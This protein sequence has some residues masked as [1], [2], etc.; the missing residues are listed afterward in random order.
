MSIGYVEK[1]ESFALVDGPGVRYCIFLKGC[2]MR[3]KY[4]HNPETWATNGGKEYTADDLFKKVYRY[5]TY[6]GKDGGITVSGGEPLL[7]IDFI[8]DLFT[9]AK[10]KGVHT[11]LDTSGNPFDKND[12]EWME[13]FN[14]LMEVTDLVMLDIKHMDGDK[15][16]ELTGC[17]NSNILDMARFLSDMGKAMWIR[18]VLVPGHTDNEDELKG[19]REFIDSLKT[20]ERVEV[21]PYHTMALAKYEELNIPYGLE[22]VRTPTNEEVKK[23]E[24][25]IVAS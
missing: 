18:R 11:T 6:W 2:D 19:L 4:C 12:K 25:I 9:Q 1:L 14:R 10:A 17:D 23:A 3:C 22:G 20:V 7:Q 5:K 15:H 24:S 8:I 16:R 13:K 21:L